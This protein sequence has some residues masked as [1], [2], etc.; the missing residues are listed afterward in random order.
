MP[1]SRLTPVSSTESRGPSYDTAAVAIIH[2]ALG[3]II[4]DLEVIRAQLNFSPKARAEELPDALLRIEEVASRTGVAVST[5]RHWRQAGTGPPSAR[6]GRRVIYRAGD[7]DAW[8]KT[9]LA[10]TT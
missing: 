9:R 7:V 1:S 3:R 8:I 2:A 5:L 6:I 4:D 10:G